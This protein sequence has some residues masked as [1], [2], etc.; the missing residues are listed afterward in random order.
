MQAGVVPDATRIVALHH[1]AAVLVGEHKHKHDKHDKQQQNKMMLV[2]PK[3]LVERGAASRF[4][5]EALCLLWKTEHNEIQKQNKT[6]ECDKE[7]LV[8]LFEHFIFEKTT[9]SHEGYSKSVCDLIAQLI[10][11]RVAQPSMLE[12]ASYS[13]VA[14]QLATFDFAS[15]VLRS[16]EQEQLAAAR[17][18]R[19]MTENFSPESIIKPTKVEYEPDSSVD[20]RCPVCGTTKIISAQVQMRGAD[21]PP[22]KL[23]RCFGAS[24]T[25]YWQSDG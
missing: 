9:G 7:L 20:E 12:D 3:Q 23:S 13:D 24:G 15:W 5:T 22:T 18:R 19:Q 16:A 11:L 21:E 14:K 10:Q 6:K 2:H 8:H 17:L 1:L 4:P 25:H